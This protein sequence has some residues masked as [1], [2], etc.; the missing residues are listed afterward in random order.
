[1]ICPEDTSLF[2][3]MALVVRSWPRR[4]GRR[5]RRRG[6]IDFVKVRFVLHGPFEVLFAVLDALAVLP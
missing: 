4:Y 1:M 6:M 2:F 3:T 5:K